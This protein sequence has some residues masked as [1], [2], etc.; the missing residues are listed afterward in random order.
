MVPKVCDVRKLEFQCLE[1]SRV[2][3]IKLNN[4]HIK[5]IILIVCSL[6]ISRE[7]SLL[8]LSLLFLLDATGTSLSSSLTRLVDSAISTPPSSSFLPDLANNFLSNFKCARGNVIDRLKYPNRGVFL[9]DVF[10][11]DDNR[12]QRKMQPN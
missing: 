8:M 2:A 6:C 3:K 11:V 9:N 10:V 1:R 7:W 12:F 4:Y 5:H